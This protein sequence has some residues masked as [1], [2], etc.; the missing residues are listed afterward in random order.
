MSMC[1]WTM[2]RPHVRGKKGGPLPDTV[3]QPSFWQSSSA[4][5]Y[6]VGCLTKWRASCSQ[7]VAPIAYLKQRGRSQISCCGVIPP[8][9]HSYMLPRTFIFVAIFEACSSIDGSVIRRLADWNTRGATRIKFSMTVLMIVLDSQISIPYTSTLLRSVNNWPCYS[10]IWN[11]SS[12]LGQFHELLDISQN[13][14]FALSQIQV[15]I[16]G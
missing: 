9:I 4:V 10:W 15:N 7:F 8:L 1:P 3:K 13:Y 5:S 12:S 16:I 14:I 11:F 2:T 6:S